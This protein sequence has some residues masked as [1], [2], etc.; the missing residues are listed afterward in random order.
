MET[1]RRLVL[2]VGSSLVLLVASAGAVAAYADVEIPGAACEQVRTAIQH[3]H[4]GPAPAR[5]QLTPAWESTSRFD[6]GG[7]C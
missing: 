2:V 7:N 5:M 6:Y 1:I 4:E 3:F